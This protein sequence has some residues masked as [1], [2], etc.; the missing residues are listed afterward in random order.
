[1]F[2]YVS[3][4]FMTFGPLL[5]IYAVFLFLNKQ[6]SGVVVADDY[7][8]IAIPVAMI[9]VGL[10]TNFLSRKVLKNQDR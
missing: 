10:L 4:P 9:M 1:M 8:A 7:I 3:I 5:C 6:K 2:F